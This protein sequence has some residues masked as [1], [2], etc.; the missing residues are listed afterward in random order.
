MYIFAKFV[1]DHIFLQ[2]RDKINIKNFP[3]EEVQLDH[4]Q[5]SRPSLSSG[6]QAHALEV[7]PVG[8]FTF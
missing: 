7:C 6:P 4:K 8:W 1:P 3:R 5:L 2:N